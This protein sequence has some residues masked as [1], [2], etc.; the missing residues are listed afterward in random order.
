MGYRPSCPFKCFT[1]LEVSRPP[2]PPFDIFDGD[3]DE[4]DLQ[5]MPVHDAAMLGSVAALL[6]T[7]KPSLGEAIFALGVGLSARTP[8]AI[9][10]P[11][12]LTAAPSI[13]AAARASRPC[14]PAASCPTLPLPVTYPTNPSSPHSAL[15]PP[16]E[17]HETRTT[18][19]LAFH[20]CT[21]PLPGSSAFTSSAHSQ[22][23]RR[24]DG[25]APQTNLSVG[26]G[27]KGCAHFR[28][29]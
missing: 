23:E 15:P 12:V 11:P 1:I 14:L 3:L 18:S 7:A 2:R 13:R 25:L 10:A 27:G 29:C 4:L 6:D 26:K 22:H 16:D 28:S 19:P 17:S 24:A 21:A 8:P 20:M 5:H 9:T